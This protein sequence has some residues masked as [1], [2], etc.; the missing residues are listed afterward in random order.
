MIGRALIIRGAL[1]FRRVTADHWLSLRPLIVTGAQFFWGPKWSEGP[2]MLFCRLP[3]IFLAAIFSK[4]RTSFL[5]EPPAS[6][7]F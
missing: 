2:D 5:C 3:H 1:L 7:A 4:T 6:R